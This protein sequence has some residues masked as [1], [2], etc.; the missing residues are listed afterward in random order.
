VI[1]CKHRCRTPDE[2]T[3]DI[4]LPEAPREPVDD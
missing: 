1:E 4:T 2:S 3:M